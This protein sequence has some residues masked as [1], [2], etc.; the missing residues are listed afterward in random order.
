[1][2]LLSNY[3]FFIDEIKGYFITVN[4]LRRIVKIAL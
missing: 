3:K 1:M 2:K 4:I